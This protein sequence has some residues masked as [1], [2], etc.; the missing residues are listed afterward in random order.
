M[1]KPHR[2]LGIFA[3]LIATVLLTLDACKSCR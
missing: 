1:M 3:G 2:M